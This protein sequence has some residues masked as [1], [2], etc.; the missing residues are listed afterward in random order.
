MTQ[1]PANAI[2][3]K[4]IAFLARLDNAPQTEIVRAELETWLAEDPRHRGAFLRA[5]AAFAHLDRLAILPVELSR[6]AFV[7]RRGLLIAGAGASAL[8]ASAVGLALWLPTRN[9]IATP[10]GEIRRVPLND[11]SVVAVNTNSEL[12]V[13]LKDNLRQLTLDKGEVWFDVAKDGKRPFVVAAG[14][15]RVMAVGTAFSVRRRDDG[16]DVL[17]TEGVVA[18]WANG[19]VLNKVL[20]EAGS[21]VFVSDIA[22]P[23]RVTAAA[24]QIDRTL[25]WRNGQIALD[26][27][28]LGAAAAEFNRY[29]TRQLTIDPALA[30]KRLVGWFHTN[31]PETFA[32]AAAA[33]LGVALTENQDEIHLAP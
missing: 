33:T 4:A 22:G 10:I 9:L 29:N 17:V 21:K 16:A 30:D 12:G 20:V 1:E 14:Q 26:G 13:D 15:V 2:D 23:S 24:H 19:D 3:A 7:S 28:S 18:A 5:E 6:P 8:A 27:M 25:A 31:E 11:G 32:K